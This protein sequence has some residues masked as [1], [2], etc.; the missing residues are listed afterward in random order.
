MK[1]SEIVD[2][3][4][5]TLAKALKVKGLQNICVDIEFNGRQ[6]DIKFNLITEKEDIVGFKG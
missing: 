4:D 3:V 1:K 5:K 2:I 6:I